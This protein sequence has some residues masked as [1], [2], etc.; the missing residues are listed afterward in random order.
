MAFAVL[1]KLT[2]DSLKIC[3]D[4][5]KRDPSFNFKIDEKYKKIVIFAKDLSDA[6]KKGYWLKYKANC[7]NFNI[8]RVVE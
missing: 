2:D 8:V 7:G 4:I 6:Y 1:I 5:A 3:Q